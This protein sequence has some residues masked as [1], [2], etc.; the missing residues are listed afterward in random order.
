MIFKKKYFLYLIYFV[1]VIFIY[2]GFLNT[3][4]VLRQKYETRMINNAGYCNAQGYGF[5]KNIVTTYSENTSNIPSLNDIDF[6]IPNGYFFDYKKKKST[7]EIILLN[8]N[9]QKLKTYLNDNY[10]IVYFIDNCYYLKK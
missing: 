1:L 8:I 6:P 5:Y 7:N 2:D 4:I 3:L 9:K 10:K